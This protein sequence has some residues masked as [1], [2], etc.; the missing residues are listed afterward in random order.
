VNGGLDRDKFTEFMSEQ[1]EDG[2]DIDTWTF[3]ELKS[4]FIKLIKFY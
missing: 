4:V 1:R 2:T 3:D